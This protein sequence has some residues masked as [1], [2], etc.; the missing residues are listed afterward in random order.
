MGHRP[1]P[2]PEL[3]DRARELGRSIAF[4][5]SVAGGIPIVAN[6]SQCLS[7]NQVTM[8]AALRAASLEGQRAV[9]LEREPAPR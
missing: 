6:I 7:A 5:A 1:G 3:F 9:R 2:H 4:E 8:W